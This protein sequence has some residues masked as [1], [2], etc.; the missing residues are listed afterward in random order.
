M[1]LEIKEKKESG[2]L[3]ERQIVV[4]IVLKIFLLKKRHN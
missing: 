2:D 3:E 1:L 4:G